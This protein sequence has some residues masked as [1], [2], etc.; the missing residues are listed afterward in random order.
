[1][2]DLQKQAKADS[3]SLRFLGSA[4]FKT[5]PLQR[6]AQELPSIPGGLTWR[7]SVMFDTGELEDCSS[8]ASPSTFRNPRSR[9]IERIVYSANRG[10]DSESSMRVVLSQYSPTVSA[11]WR[12][13]D[14]ESAERLAAIV[15]DEIRN[16]RTFYWPITAFGA[17]AR[18]GW[19][20]T[21]LLLLFFAGMIMPCVQPAEESQP[22][23]H[24]ELTQAPAG[25]QHAR[26]PW[27]QRAWR[28]YG[29]VVLAAVAMLIVIWLF[30]Q[31]V[32]AVGE[33]VDR[34]QWIVKWRLLLFS[35]VVLRQVMQWAT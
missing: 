1:M 11:S 4:V 32:F 34:Y 2:S 31:G 20:G 13:V 5:E 22:P 35:G 29:A 28:S 33:G 18:S 21:V 7:A 16:V 27:V 30:P 23:T 14:P 25:E 17:W 6:F 15:R 26:A 10:E 19:R 8:L 24:R 9:Q 3:A 12:G